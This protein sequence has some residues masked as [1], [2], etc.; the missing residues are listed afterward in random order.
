M[1]IGCI[2]LR[3]EGCC[4]MSQGAVPADT[5]SVFVSALGHELRQKQEGLRVA[6]AQ[7][8]AQQTLAAEL[9]AV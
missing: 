1:L 9:G 8:R 4:H 6:R 2:E 3:L 5:G 7:A